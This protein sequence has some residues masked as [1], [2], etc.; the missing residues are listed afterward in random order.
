MTVVSIYIVL[1][2]I[3]A[4]ALWALVTGIRDLS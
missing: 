2:L 4:V 1:A 3:V